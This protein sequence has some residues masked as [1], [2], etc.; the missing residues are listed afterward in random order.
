MDNQDILQRIQD[1]VDEEHELRSTAEDSGNAATGQD[2][3]G[4]ERRSRL[5]RVEEELDQYWDLLRQ[6]RAKSAASDD[7]DKA[8][9]RP[10]SEVEGYGQ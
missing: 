6:R 1:L 3:A 8:D 2:A 7:P 9:I 4:A 5:R 10:V